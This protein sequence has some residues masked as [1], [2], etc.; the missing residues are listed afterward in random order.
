MTYMTKIFELTKEYVEDYKLNN[1]EWFSFANKCSQEEFLKSQ[2]GFY[3]AVKSFSRILSKLASKIES[4]EARILIIEN[5]WEEHG[6]GN[7][8]FFHTNTYF[9]YLQSLGFNKKQSEIQKQ[10][11]VTEWINKVLNKDYSEEN[12]AMYIAGIEYIYARVSQFI[13]NRI[14][15]Y[16]L[17]CSQNHYANHAVL[18]Y[19]HSKEL[20]TTSLLIQKE[21]GSLSDEEMMY[22]FKLGISE[23]LSLYDNMILLTEEEAVEICKEKHAFYYGREDTSIAKNFLQSWNDLKIKNNDKRQANVLTICS[24]GENAIE[25]LSMEYGHNITLLDINPNQLILAKEKIESIQKDNNLSKDLMIFNTGKFE[26]IFSFVKKSFTYEELEQISLEN[27][28]AL[29][30]FKWICD[31][32]FSNRILEIVFT[33]NA[34]KYSKDNFSD[35]FYSLFVKQIKWYFKNKPEF[36]NV[37]SIFFNTEPINYQVK[38]NP[39]NSINYYHGDFLSF[40]KESDTKFDLIDL[41]NISDWM[42]FGE[43]QKIVFTAY[44]NL[45]KDGVIVGRKLLGDYNWIDLQKDLKYSTLLPLI[46]CTSFYSECVFIKKL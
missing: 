12:Y 42:P 35:H 1:H 28:L 7:K 16:S 40:F 24:G 38:I 18:D 21:N 44:S 15:S 2:E 22:Y 27:P 17:S 32:A 14:E 43:M 33:D 37:G 20:I 10:P 19:E 45:N 30:K 46:D 8:E 3:Y 34:T 11:W 6:H 36:S 39:D 9:Q 31:N 26:K 29:N 4:S 25:L 5:L 41:S 23:F 13:A